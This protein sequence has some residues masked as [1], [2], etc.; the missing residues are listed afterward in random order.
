MHRLFQCFIK[1]LDAYFSIFTKNFQTINKLVKKVKKMRTILATFVEYSLFN[2]QQNLP[3]H[4]SQGKWILIAYTKKSQ[5]TH[6][7]FWC[8][9]QKCANLR[10]PRFAS[11]SGK[12]M[13][14]ILSL[15]LISLVVIAYYS[16]SF[17]LASFQFWQWT[18]ELTA[19]LW[20]RDGT[21]VSACL[22]V[23]TELTKQVL[24]FIRLAKHGTVG[25]N[26]NL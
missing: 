3:A 2:S 14:P 10:L 24:F 22:S 13:F 1:N 5:R 25:F 6:G 26:C 15:L 18:N 9:S 11:S 16:F 19:I 23:S 20:M 8:W 12:F 17:R 7:A 21:K 4:L